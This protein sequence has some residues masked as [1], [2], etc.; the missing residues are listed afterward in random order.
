MYASSSIVY[1]LSSTPES[2]GRTVA[3]ALSIGTPVIGWN[4]GGVAEILAAQFPNGAVAFGNVDELFAR[5]SAILSAT[6]R[7]VPGPN[8]FGKTDML[9]RTL[10]V[11][12]AA[13]RAHAANRT[14]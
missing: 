11:Y 8:C 14:E 6:P 10:D 7:P 3:E 2:F 9:R 13:H 5:T 12:L 1:S 4:H